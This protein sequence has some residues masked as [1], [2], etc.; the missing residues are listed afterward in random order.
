MSDGRLTA[1]RDVLRSRVTEPDSVEVSGWYRSTD[2][3]V[4]VTC[5]GDDLD[6][7]LSIA[8]KAFRVADT[9]RASI[10]ALVTNYAAIAA[11][12]REHA[13]AS[14]LIEDYG[15]AAEYIESADWHD[16]FASD[17]RQLLEEPSEEKK[18]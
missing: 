5:H 6:E 3:G 9:L 7:A 11:N 1:L 14:A 18:P 10:D 13:K 4:T 17:L 8:V 15:A 2:G 16:R 12:D